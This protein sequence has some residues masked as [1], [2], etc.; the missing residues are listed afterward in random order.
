MKKILY[1]VSIAL[2]SHCAN[3]VGPTGGDKDI[4]P[5]KLIKTKIITENNTKKITLIFDENINTKGS[6]LLSPITIKKNIE[7]NKHRN[8][9]WFNVPIETNSISL[10]DV[11]TDVNENNLGRYPF[12]V[13]GSDSQKYVFNYKSSNPTKDKIKSYSK[14]DSFLYYG[15]NTKKGRIGIEGMKKQSQ[16][17]YTFNDLNNNDKYDINEDSY[18]K[19]INANQLFNPSDSIKDTTTIIIY[20]SVLKEIKK[21]HQNKSGI[22]IYTQI[23]KYFIQKETLK[24]NIF[25]IGHSDS[26]II[27]IGD[28]TYLENEIKKYY[29]DVKFIDAKIEIKPSKKYDTKI[30]LFEKDT[31]LELE[32]NLGYFIDQIQKREIVLKNK[33]E[34]EDYKIK[35]GNNT[36]I[37]KDCD[38]E[39]IYYTLKNQ[40]LLN[41]H[42]PL[43]RDSIVKKIKIKLGKITI[44]NNN[45]KESLKVLIQSEGK[46]ILIEHL[47]N[48]NNDFFLPIGNYKYII[49]QDLNDNGEI[50][51]K[52]N[53]KESI[54]LNEDIQY[55]SIIEYM[56]ETSVNSKLDNTIIVE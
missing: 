21:S 20:P 50:D 28:T 32:F 1:I 39:K 48:N 2:F 18:I 4:H 37:Y 5:P 45:K 35:N 55:E 36:S 27:N 16:Y 41:L 12:I 33:T 54:Q 38:K 3:P 46:I 11:I 7:I 42:N 49:W 23:P 22:S 14:I 13:L 30:G 40:I 8:T 43:K 26:I 52:N 31:I 29:P 10:G 25:F 17:I 6:L 47:K 24:E 56:K 15:D 19:R 34:I 9:I 44:K 51:T 53:I